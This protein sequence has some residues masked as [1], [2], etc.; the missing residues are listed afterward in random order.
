[1]NFKLDSVFVTIVLIVCQHV[2]GLGD[3]EKHAGEE[4]KHEREKRFVFLQTAGLGV[5]AK[6]FYNFCAVF[7]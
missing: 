2:N 1:M 7:T 4:N 5:S 6:T 3:L